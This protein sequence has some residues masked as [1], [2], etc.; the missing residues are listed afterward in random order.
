MQSSKL[1]S[2]NKKHSVKAECFFYQF[3]LILFGV[4]TAFIS[5]FSF[6]LLRQ[7]LFPITSDSN[8]NLYP[9]LVS[10]FIAIFI[11]PLL[12]EMI[13]RNWF[14]PFLKKKGIRYRYAIVISATIFASLHFDW[15]LFP[16]LI[17]GIIYGIVRI[18]SNNTYSSILVHSLYN[19]LILL[20][21][22][23]Q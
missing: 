3:K 12:E 14:I 16:Y 9:T 7:W 15:W 20:P 13:F 10:I 1:I 6:A 11:S 19:A 4:I 8:S 2:Q 21:I 18:K 23:I 17:N 22:L 5:S